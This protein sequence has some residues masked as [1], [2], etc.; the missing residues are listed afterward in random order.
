M[1]VQHGAQWEPGWGRDDLSA[2]E[3]ELLWCLRRLAMMRP[4][5]SA[6]DAHVHLALQRRFGDEGLGAEHLLRCLLVA[7]A[8][9]AERPLSLRM[10]C[11]PARTT[12][13]TRLLLAWRDPAQVPVMLSPMAG[14]RAAELQPII[15]A[16]GG[17]L[18]R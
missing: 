8:R 12:D 1:F 10:P 9:R 15:A 4:L 16:L 18:R 3:R 5:G 13:E 7:L 6:R 11:C 17:L 14:T 2:A